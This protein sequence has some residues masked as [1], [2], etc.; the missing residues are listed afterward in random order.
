MSGVEVDPD[1]VVATASSL[2]PL[3]A[4]VRGPG[5]AIKGLAAP[6]EAPLTAAFS[7]MTT[8]W[9]TALDLLA[10]DMELL[11]GKVS[12]AGTQYRVTEREIHAAFGRASGPVDFSPP[13]AGGPR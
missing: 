11:A 10:Q 4:D 8:A 13:T 3:A 12:T 7:G 5:A 9:G 2:R 6:A 1:A